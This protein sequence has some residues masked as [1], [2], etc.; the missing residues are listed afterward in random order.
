MPSSQE[1]PTYQNGQSSS[2]TD[3]LNHHS[4]SKRPESPPPKLQKT[5]SWM[6]RYKLSKEFRSINDEDELGKLMGDAGEQLLAFVDDIHKIE[7]LRKIEL[8]IPQVIRI[9]SECK[10][11]PLLI[12]SG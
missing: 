5:A 1:S 6:A 12:R 10:S 9:L 4:D 8:G 3:Q 2:G 7:S 11:K